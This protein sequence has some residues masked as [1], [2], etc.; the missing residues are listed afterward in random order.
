MVAKSETG[1]AGQ[2]AVYLFLI[3]LFL[4]PLGLI[5]WCVIG[6][7]RSNK[8]DWVTRLQKSCL[9]MVA[10]ASLFA[11]LYVCSPIL[12]GILTGEFFTVFRGHRTVYNFA[13]A[14]IR[15]FIGIS[16]LLTQAA[17]AG[18]PAYLIIRMLKI[19]ANKS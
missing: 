15:F 14:P 4:A 17:L 18:M 13:D 11:S 16:G 3:V 8:N 6:L 5:A 19:S 2:M 12:D 7:M 9:I 1:V 10:L